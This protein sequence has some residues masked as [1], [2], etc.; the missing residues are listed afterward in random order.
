MFIQVKLFA[1]LAVFSP[2]G[3]KAGSPFRMELP[4]GTA[5][6][7]LVHRLQLPSEEVKLCFVNGR[8]QEL[9]RTLRDGDEVGIFPPIG[10]GSHG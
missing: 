6:Q 9:E 7:Q 3:G 5:L 1:T 4:E 10:G 2:S 8:L